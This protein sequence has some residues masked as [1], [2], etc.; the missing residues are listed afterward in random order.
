MIEAFYIFI[1]LFIIKLGTHINSTDQITI[2]YKKKF[3]I[4]ILKPEIFIFLVF[5]LI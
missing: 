3:T 2:Y 5:V 1:L 4:L